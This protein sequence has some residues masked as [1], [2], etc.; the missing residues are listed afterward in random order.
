MAKNW[1]PVI[2]YIKCKECGLCIKNC[3]D[4][5]YDIT[6]APSPFIVRPES[7][8]DHCHSCGN[9]CLSGAIT[10]FGDNTG[11]IPPHGRDVSDSGRCTDGSC[12]LD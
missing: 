7:C 2:D 5:V 9:R 6:K 8:I 3:L 11:W 10:Y 4:H 1:Y 12:D